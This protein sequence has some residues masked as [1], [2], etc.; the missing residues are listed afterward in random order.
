MIAMILVNLK[1]ISYLGPEMF[2]VY[3]TVLAFTSFFKIFTEASGVDDVLITDTADGESSQEDFDSR[4]TTAILL[5]LILG[6]GAFSLATTIS[7]AM[8]YDMRTYSLIVLLSLGMLFSFNKRKNPFIIRYIVSEKRFIPELITFLVTGTILI[9]KLALAIT[10][11]PLWSFVLSDLTLIFGLSTAFLT[12]ALRSGH[13]A[14]R[15]RNFRWDL[16]RELFRRSL[17]ISISG[18]FVMVFMRIDQIMLSKMIG[19]EAVGIY[20]VAVLLVEGPNVII[21]IAATLLL[22]IFSRL[23]GNQMMSAILSLSFRA[24]AWG[25]LILV[26]LY[27]LFGEY[28]LRALWGE[29]YIASLMPLKVLAWSALFM[30]VGGLHGPIMV[31]FDL[32]RYAPILVS[33]QASVN[34]LLNFLLIPKHGPT[35]AAAATCLSYLSGFLFALAFKN[36][37]FFVKSSWREILPLTLFIAPFILPWPFLPPPKPVL[38][39][40]V[41]MGATL[42]LGLLSIRQ[43][44]ALSAALREAG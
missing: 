13:F 39:I 36:L 43:V 1:I 40:P 34:V 14:I 44:G 12:V 8:R 30:W 38:V 24:T 35:G 26:T 7:L 6:V 28:I 19:M 33:F 3:S 2:G 11:A 16:A 23:R 5:R 37:R 21:M 22:P 20:S 31:A 18:M 15:L 32:T 4:L 41:L 10:G 17:P 29:Q 9:V 42:V 27:S 25:S